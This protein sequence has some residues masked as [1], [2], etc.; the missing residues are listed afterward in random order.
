VTRYLCNCVQYIPGRWWLQVSQ[1]SPVGP[2]DTLHVCI[3]GVGWLQVSQVTPVGPRDTLHV[4]IPGGW[5]LHVSQVTP[6]GPGDTLHVC[7]YSWSG[8]AAGQPGH[9]C[10]SS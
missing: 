8:V 5:W 6:V 3:P 2:G 10:R 7:T 4:Y 1:V 9:S